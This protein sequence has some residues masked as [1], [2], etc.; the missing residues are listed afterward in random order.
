MGHAM[1]SLTCTLTMQFPML[2][3]TVATLTVGFYCFPQPLQADVGT[4]SQMKQ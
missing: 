4:G 1:L 2:F 3:I